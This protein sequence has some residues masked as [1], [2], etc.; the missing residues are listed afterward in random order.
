MT[1]AAVSCSLASC[2]RVDTGADIDLSGHTVFTVGTEQLDLSGINPFE[3]IWAV[4]ESI[5]VFGED[6]VNMEFL[7]RKSSEGRITADFYGHVI[8]G[9][10]ILAY[11]P[12]DAS[13]E[14][15]SEGNVP[16]DL[17]SVQN[18]S[19]GMSVEEFFLGN[20]KRV[21]ASDKDG[22]GLLEFRYPFGLLKVE[23]EIGDLLMTG[24]SLKGSGPLS[25]RFGVDGDIRLNGTALS[26]DTV[27]L[28]FGGSIIPGLSGGNPSYL[29]FV[30]PP[31]EYEE[32]VLRI[33][34]SVSGEMEL[35]LSNI[36]VAR[37]GT[38]NF[39]LTSVRVGM[40]DI[41]GLSVEDGYLE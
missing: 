15:D 25:G 17:P 12:F 20:V 27:S 37:L 18:F 23:T 16:C 2:T 35:R 21:F 10:N 19:E 33:E 29:L 22:S 4:G 28:D 14:L 13:V 38:G 8:R 26:F 30:I 9:N 36:V 24:A 3:K 41:P 39:T 6:G 1:I 40:S 5:G 7:L 31:G 32:L 34:D 11:S